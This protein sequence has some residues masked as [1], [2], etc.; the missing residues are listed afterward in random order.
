MAGVARWR[1]QRS[2]APGDEV[3]QIGVSDV[4]WLGSGSWAVDMDMECSFIRRRRRRR[5][6]PLQCICLLCIV[7][8]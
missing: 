3:R 7:D 4:T 5:C 2:D 1:F 8:A 6:R